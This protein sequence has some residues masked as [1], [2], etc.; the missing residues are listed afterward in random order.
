MAEK[1]Q[2]QLIA[3]STAVQLIKNLTVFLMNVLAWIW[4]TLTDLIFH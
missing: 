3:T 2:F 4:K 1:E